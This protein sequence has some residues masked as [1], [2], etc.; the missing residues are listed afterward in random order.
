M[1]NILIVFFI[2]CF[3]FLI[4][5][6]P[7]KTRLMGHLNLLD[8]K[9]YYS[10]KSWIIRLLTGKIFIENGK[11]VMTNEN[12]IFSKTYDDFMK[13]LSREILSKVDIKKMELFFS[14]G[15]K[16]NSF[17]SAIACGVMVS[18]VEVMFGYLSLKYD[19]VKMYKDIK[20]TFEEDNL[21]L[22][23]DIV[24]SVSLWRLV[25]CFFD[26]SK[27]VKKLKEIENER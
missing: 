8:L 4:T 23:V 19:D 15:F 11:I 21:E 3:V 18:M 27:K 2:I 10:V 17:T 6:L 12:T 9:C 20:P 25:K 24:V 13:E 16:E 26:T 7:F 22:T 5:I 1:R 14:G